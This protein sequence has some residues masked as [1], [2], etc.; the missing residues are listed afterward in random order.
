MFP[1]GANWPSGRGTSPR[2]PSVSGGRTQARPMGKVRFGTAGWD[3]PDWN[4]FVFP[5]PRPKDF[6]PLAYLA[7]YFRT[8]E[9]N[10]S[11]YRPATAAIAKKW[12]N[13][14]DA[15][16]H[17]R[18]TA[19]LWKRFTHERGTAWSKDDVAAPRRPMFFTRPGGLARCCCSFRGHSRTR[20][21]L[22]GVVARL[23]PLVRPPPNRPRGA[24]S[25]VGGAEG[26]RVAGRERRRPRQHRPAAV[27]AIN[28]AG[29]PW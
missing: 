14:V 2:P 21:A 18:F 22:A 28:Q 19:K 10:N 29:R 16:P 12:V 9:I 3:Y 25:V 17:F 6:D 4:G 5:I 11:F 26:P 1:A 27:Q 7:R 8:V 23:V 24:A 15:Q 20:D 13:R